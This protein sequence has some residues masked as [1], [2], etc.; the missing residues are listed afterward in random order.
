MS[1]STAYRASFLL[2]AVDLIVA[3]ICAANGDAHF[4]A[5]MVL[6]GLMWAQGLYLMAKAEKETGE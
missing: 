3:T 4:M 2:A 1:A 6:A 5:F